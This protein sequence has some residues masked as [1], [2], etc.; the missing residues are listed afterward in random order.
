MIL[1]IGEWV[2]N[3]ACAQLKKL[4]DM[5]FAGCG[6][7]VNVSPIQLQHPY[8]AEIVS[9]VVRSSGLKPGSLILEIT[10]SKSIISNHTAEKNLKKLKKQGVKLS[11]DDF[12]T[13]FCSL[14]YL[15]RYS[16]NSLKVDRRFITDINAKANKAIV[17]MIITLGH[18]LDMPIIAEGVE[19]KE[20]YEYLVSI[21]CDMIQGFYLTKPVR[22]EDIPGLLEV[23]R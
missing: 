10:E 11:I 8:F 2:L 15:Q 17:E 23:D 7:S 4:N 3:N 14:E 16:I 1:P 12:C 19:T 22:P 6:M 21:G 18:R 9:N 20:Q 13:G 5:G